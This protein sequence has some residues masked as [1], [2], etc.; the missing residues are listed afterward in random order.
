[1]TPLTINP[2]DH[3]TRDSTEYKKFKQKNCSQV[4][5][6]SLFLSCLNVATSHF[7]YL[8]QN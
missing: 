3:T 1:M 7:V 6:K 4:I 2:F 5:I 8:K